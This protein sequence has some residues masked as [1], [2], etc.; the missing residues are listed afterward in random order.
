MGSKKDDKR[1]EELFKKASSLAADGRFSKDDYESLFDDYGKTKG[2]AVG[3]KKSDLTRHIARALHEN[4][5]VLDSDA[6]E[7]ANK[8][9]KGIFGGYELKQT[10]DSRGNLR[11]S[12]KQSQGGAGPRAH[13]MRPLR[14]KE[15]E[16]YEGEFDSAPI[17][18]IQGKSWTQHTP[19][20]SSTSKWDVYTRTYT[21]APA[22]QEKDEPVAEG[23][24]T[25]PP[26]D[27]ILPETAASKEVFD[28]YQARRSEGS[29]PFIPTG[30]GVGDAA[31][32]GNR[33]GFDFAGRFLG[34]LDAT[35][36]HTANE[37]KQSGKFN[38]NRFVAEV[39]ELGDPK[40]AFEHYADKIG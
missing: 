16:F 21:H 2:W 28:G 10:K 13:G 35:A 23:E 26:V 32:Y 24:A 34:D 14:G 5:A 8:Y 38:L 9:N 7:L 18:N 15:G 40:K 4:N 33:A 3:G 12:F 27:T 29:I 19:N 11:T 1:R 20:G 39:P 36:M 37:I 25:P 31:D 30:D 6:Q 22:A 17:T